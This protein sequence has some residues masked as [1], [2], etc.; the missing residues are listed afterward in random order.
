MQELLLYEY[1][2]IRLV[3]CVE[4]AEFINIGVILFCK[5]NK[6]LDLRFHLD[7]TKINLFTSDLDLP[8]IKQQ[9]DAFKMICWGAKQGGSMAKEPINYRFRWLAANRSTIIQFSKI[10]SGLT[11]DPES[12][13]NDLL[14]KMVL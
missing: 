4:R 12:T 8:F 14:E 10:H 2:V 13:L 6:F 3:P 11:N 7:E 1:A 9:V 5:Q